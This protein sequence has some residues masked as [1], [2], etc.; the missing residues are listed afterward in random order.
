[1]K[2]NT[3][4]WFLI[5]GLVV[6]SAVGGLYYLFNEDR[7]VT[8]QQAIASLDQGI[9]LFREKKYAESL[10]ILQGIPAGVLQDWHLPYYKAT[11]HVMLKDYESAAP[12]LEHALELNPQNTSIMFELGVI[13]YKLG[14]L[15]L[16]KGYFASVVAIDP[17]NEEAKGL[18]DIMAKLDRQQ[19]A[20]E[21]TDAPENDQA[22]VQD[23]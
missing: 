10:D 11:A 19:P 3:R 9:A 4:F 13:Y 20:T 18:M 6:F 22:G 15:A 17:S 2:K 5:L 23:H 16:S 14:N 12:I 1:M 8:E 7:K 21:E